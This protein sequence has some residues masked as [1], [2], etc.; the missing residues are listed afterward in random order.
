[1]EVSVSGSA[2]GHGRAELRP[3]RADTG[4][5]PRL[6]GQV[7]GQRRGHEVPD[8]QGPGD[9]GAVPDDRRDDLAGGVRRELAVQ[10]PPPPP[11]NSTSDREPRTALLRRDTTMDGADG[12]PHGPVGAESL[13]SLM[14]MHRDLGCFGANPG[15][16]SS[17]HAAQVRR[18]TPRRPGQRSQRSGPV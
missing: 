3:G 15:T 12:S 1:M 14:Q 5:S 13:A 18:L 7:D 9:P 2:C 17:I 16:A 11:A 4:A 10:P 6:P 8:Q